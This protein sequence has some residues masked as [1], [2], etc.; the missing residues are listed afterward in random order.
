[1][2]INPVAANATRASTATL[3]A[4]FNMFLRLLT[5][6]L[7]YQ[8]PLDP[9]DTS[10][11]TQQLVSYSQVEQAIQQTSRLDQILARM[12][13]QD[14]AAASSYIGREVT[15][16]QPTTTLGATGATWFYDLQSTAAAARLTILDRNGLPVRQIAGPTTAGRHEI[17]WDGTDAN[18]R[19]MPAGDYTL[20]VEAVTASG[21]QV[22]SRVGT[23]GT[24]TGVEQL[25][26]DILLNLGSG[27]IRAADIAAIAASQPAQ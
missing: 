6:Q 12:S 13:G 1:M 16:Y 11:Y 22:A 23:R 10:E 26:G 18:G 15:A 24:V 27:R 25:A 5:T 8:D 4:D 9:M 21:Q 14:L 17:A 7:Q 19:R 3:T 20:V 2:D